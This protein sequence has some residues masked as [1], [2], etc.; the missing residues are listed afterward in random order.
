MDVGSDGGSIPAPLHRRHHLVVPRRGKR[1]SR[2]EGPPPAQT[3]ILHFC[4]RQ[5]SRLTGVV[6]DSPAARR[7]ADACPD[8]GVAELHR[9]L[10]DGDR[11]LR[12]ALSG[13][14]RCL[15]A[16]GAPARHRGLRSVGP[17]GGDSR[18]ESV[19]LGQ[20]SHLRLCRW[21]DEH[22]SRAPAGSLSR[23]ADR[24]VPA[25]PSRSGARRSARPRR[26]AACIHRRSAA[27][28]VGSRRHDR[29]GIVP[30]RR[31]LL[32]D[33]RGVHRS[34]RHNSV[35]RNAVLDNSTRSLCNG[36]AGWRHASDIRAAVRCGGSP[37]RG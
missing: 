21:R 13:N 32:A 14:A 31:P 33:I 18:T 8:R 11:S 5:W 22:L 3:R 12:S 20:P 25:D 10:G 26:W 16:G 17:T 9:N 23:M 29:D 4:C 15:E 19:F 35:L 1:P 28:D 37:D 27:H 2:R 34:R 6:R 7:R 24:S 36:G 30:A